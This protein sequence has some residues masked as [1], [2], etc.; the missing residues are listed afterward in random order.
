M[1]LIFCST[2]SQQTGNIFTPFNHHL[3]NITRN[4]T[5]HPQ[6]ICLCVMT[7]QSTSPVFQQVILN[8][9]NITFS[10]NGQLRAALFIVNHSNKIIKA[11]KHDT[12]YSI[13]SLDN[14]HFSFGFVAECDI[15]R[16]VCQ[17]IQNS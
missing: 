4:L 3:V 6:E 17:L 8:H 9:D 1:K 2:D 11:Y 5:L 15:H 14:M 7:T 10:P 16:Y 13:T 12:L